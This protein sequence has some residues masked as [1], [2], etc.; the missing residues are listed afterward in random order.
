MVSPILRQTITHRADRGA[1]SQ[2][3]KANAILSVSNHP[4]QQ[5]GGVLVK[6]VEND[7]IR[8]SLIGK[9]ANLVMEAKGNCDKAQ[10]SIWSNLM[11]EIAIVLEANLETPSWLPIMQYTTLDSLGRFGIPYLH[12]VIYMVA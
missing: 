5:S 7:V 3:I 4:K 1:R 2:D 6:R 12:N 8:V 11:E 9:V 10:V